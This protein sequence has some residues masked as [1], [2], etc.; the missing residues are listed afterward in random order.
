[1]WYHTQDKLALNKWMKVGDLLRQLL[2]RIRNSHLKIEC[3]EQLCRSR[4]YKKSP[5]KNVGVSGIF[6]FMRLLVLQE[7]I[8]IA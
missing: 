7:D 1:M 2:M 5:V 6:R 3:M 8:V 4:T